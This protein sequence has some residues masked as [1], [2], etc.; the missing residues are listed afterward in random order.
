MAPFFCTYIKRDVFNKSCGFNLQLGKH[1]HSVR[2]FSEFI[3][4]IL[5]LKIYHISDSI[6]IHNTTESYRNS[7]PIDDEY[8][9]TL[10]ENNWDNSSSNDLSFERFVWDF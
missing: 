3:R 9:Y 7:E 4:N 10:D 5:N 1:Y 2:L 6:V 8:N